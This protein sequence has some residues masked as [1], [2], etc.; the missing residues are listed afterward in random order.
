MIEK[1]PYCGNTKTKK[2]IY[3]F[4]L[5]NKCYSKMI[6]RPYSETIMKIIVEIPSKEK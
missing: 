5:K 4:C 3:G 1:C 6:H 2:D